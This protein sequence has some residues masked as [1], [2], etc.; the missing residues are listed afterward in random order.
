[1]LL[2]FHIIKGRCRDTKVITKREMELIFQEIA[3]DELKQSQILMKAKKKQKLNISLNY[4]LNRTR[5][6][7]TVAI[8]NK[9]KVTDLTD[10]TGLYVPNFQTCKNE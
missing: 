1:M 7:G 5:S 3:L 4:D 8:T 10:L 2:A 6:P 9:F